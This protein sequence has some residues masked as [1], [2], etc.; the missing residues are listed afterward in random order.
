MAAI[1]GWVSRATAFTA[2]FS[3]RPKR[4]D[5]AGCAVQH[6][7]DVRARGEGPLTAVEHD[8]ADLR[9]AGDLTGNLQQFTDG[10]RC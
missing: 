6:L 5:V 9:V 2:S 3:A 7:L 8:G 10:S 4:G 1:T